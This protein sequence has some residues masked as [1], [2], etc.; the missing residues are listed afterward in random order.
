MKMRFLIRVETGRK[1]F[2]AR[3]CWP[4]SEC[5]ANLLVITNSKSKAI[6]KIHEKIALF[7]EK[8][9]RP[10]FESRPFKN[11]IDC[12]QAYID[13]PIDNWKCKD[14]KGPCPLQGQLDISNQNL[15][16]SRCLVSEERKKGILN[17]ITTGKYNGFHHIPGR[18]LCGLCN[19]PRRN[20]NYHFPWELTRLYDHCEL[21]SIRNDV[22]RARELILEGFSFSALSSALCGECFLKVSDFFPEVH[23]SDYEILTYDYR[24]TG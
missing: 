24:R 9:L 2:L 17:A 3:T 4:E 6:S 1:K 10:S 8:K 22:N 16:L 7:V 14:S 19:K 12:P 11:L 20:Y 23:R 21:D 13:L 5:G 15:F 18:Y